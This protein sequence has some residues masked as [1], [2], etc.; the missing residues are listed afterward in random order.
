MYICGALQLCLRYLD[1]TTHEASTSVEAQFEFKREG[2][3]S[4]QASPYLVDVI[5]VGLNGTHV[6]GCNY[7][8]R[9]PLSVGGA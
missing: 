3:A 5:Q 6:T 4:L 1:G 7:N 2:L 9:V 8:N